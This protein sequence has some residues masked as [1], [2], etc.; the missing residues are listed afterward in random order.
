M[1][2]VREG[3]KRGWFWID[4]DIIDKMGKTMGPYGLAVYSVLAR[5]LDKDDTCFPS[6]GYIGKLIGCSDRT[7]RRHIDQLEQLGLITVGRTFGKSH[8]YYVKRTPDRGSEVCGTIEE[9]P[10]Y[11]STPPDRGSGVPRTQL[12]TNKTYLTRPNN[13]T[14][15]IALKDHLKDIRKALK[16]GR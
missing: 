8:H 14:E 1:P 13:K 5:H 6:T 4:N 11:V 12:P 9:T 15:P 16:P 7:V 2:E 10:E 3:R